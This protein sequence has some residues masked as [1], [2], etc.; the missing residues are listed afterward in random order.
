TVGGNFS[1]AGATGSSFA[2]SGSHLTVFGGAAQTISFVDASGLS[3][4]AILQLSSATSTTALTDVMADSALMPTSAANFTAGVVTL[5]IN[6]G[7][8]DPNGHWRVPTT[9]FEGATPTLP[10]AM[11]GNVIFKG[12]PAT[13]Q[14][15]SNVSGVLTVDTGELIMNGQSLTMAS[16]F[17]QNGGR[18][19]MTQG[20]EHLNVGGNA[21]FNGG[22]ETGLMTNGVLSLSG[23][24]VQGTTA[25]SFV[26]APIFV[27]RFNGTSPAITFANPTTSMFG[28]LE[29]AAT[30]G[31]SINSNVT[32]AGG[33]WV[34]TGTVPSGV[35]GA[36]DSVFIGSDLFDS[37]GG[38]WKVGTTVMNGVN[39]RVPRTILHNLTFANANMLS[40]SLLVSGKLSVAGAS[41]LLDLNGHYVCVI[42]S[43][44]TASGGVLKMVSPNDSLIVGGNVS[45][46]GG[47]TA[48]KLTDGYMEVQGS[49]FTQGTTAQSFSADGPHETNF[50]DAN[51]AVTSHTIT[52][53][54]PS[55]ANSHFGDVY[56][57]DTLTVLGSDVYAGG[58]LETGVSSTHRVTTSTGDHRLATNGADVR[59][60][61]FD[62]TRWLLQGSD[63]INSM[64]DVTFENISNTA[65]TQFEWNR[66]GT[67]TRYSGLYGW[68]FYTQPTTTGLY[69]KM[70]SSAPVDT[71]QM[72]VNT[73]ALNGGFIQALGG[74]AIIGWPNSLSWTGSVN[75]DFNNPSNWSVYAVP[76]SFTDVTIPPGATL[77]LSQNSYVKS[78][79]VQGSGVLAQGNYNLQV[80]GDLTTDTLVGGITCTGSDVSGITYQTAG[81]SATLQGRLC[82]YQSGRPI[83]QT[84]LV[85]VSKVF[86][87]GDSTYTFNSHKVVTPEA[88]VGTTVGATGAL[89]MIH[90]ADSLIVSDSLIVG[91]NYGASQ[92]AGVSTL[93]SGVVSVGGKYQVWGIPGAGY[94]NATPS[95]QTFLTGGSSIA[96]SDTS[97]SGFGT[98]TV[99][100]SRTLASVAR[101]AGDFYLVGGSSLVG[102]TGRLKLIGTLW[103]GT[104]S[105]ITTN[106]FEMASLNSDSGTFSPDTAVYTGTGQLITDA[107]AISIGTYN[108]KSIRVAGSATFATATGG[109]LV[110]VGG[111]LLVTGTARIGNGSTLYVVVGDSLLTHGSGVVQMVDGASYLEVLGNAWFDG[112]STSGQLT[113]GTLEFQKNF[114]Q[115]AT[116]S[117]LS[118]AP[119]S[120]HI[121]KF[122]LYNQDTVSFATPGTGAGGSHFGAL[123]TANTEPTVGVHLNSNV[124]VD[125]V[126]QMAAP[127]SDSV[128]FS[129]SGV[130][131]TAQGALVAGGS[132]YPRMVFNDVLFKL[133]DGGTF[134][135]F[136]GATFRNFGTSTAF[137]MARSSGTYTMTGLRWEGTPLGGNFL[138]ISGASPTVNLVTPYPGP[139]FWLLGLY[140]LN[141]TGTLNFLP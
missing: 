104:S 94:F 130:T 88:W 56:F 106:A 119:S 96:F 133:V 101:V 1:Q 85:T 69:I 58:E 48:G 12:N 68:S 82:R 123:L 4:F 26:A 37:T 87:V 49:Q 38:R 113:A 99:N 125:G 43:F 116:N 65:A 2:A 46:N 71:L 72:G 34:Q 45:F 136:D 40:D 78:L 90:A 18:V 41:A 109:S 132:P 27:T 114:K 77:A 17:T 57:G 84:G 137:E 13:L 112:G 73:P 31:V 14:S 139:S 128:T 118:Y 103:G 75:S 33:V 66:A 86:H 107:L 105:S 42:G 108:Y 115:T 39:A 60:L 134:T 93:T 9:E 97:A 36:T 62:N 120:G 126:L 55:L 19:K 16:F 89:K 138:N 127:A 102:S 76:D 117:S 11:S 92:S 29:L 35:T 63:D 32:V 28:K 7:L 140:F 5:R 80:H 98:L 25:T 44:S 3:K 53:A 111:N 51:P 83:T 95:L 122:A 110:T 70:T 59:N 15:T 47:S 131:L 124:F 22:D 81:A 52:F 61:T 10:A 129:G 79:T 23:N 6:R 20:T 24:F 74:G 141:P 67:G 21:T 121:T 8:S 100:G 30:T 91:G 64:D 135:A 50:V 54:N